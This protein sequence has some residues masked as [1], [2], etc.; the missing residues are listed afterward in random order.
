MGA[1]RSAS[2]RRAIF[3]AGMMS[4]AGSPL[5]ETSATTTAKR[6]SSRGMKS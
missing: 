6:S 4:A 5:P 2:V 3:T 1:W